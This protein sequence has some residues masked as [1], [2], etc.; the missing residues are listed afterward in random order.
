[1]DVFSFITLFGGLALFLYGMTVMS[2][3]LE[4]IAGGQLETILRNMTSNKYKALG[5]GAGVTA[6]IQS[7]SAVTV[8]LVGLVNS[9]IM[10]TNQSIGVIMGSN[11]GTTATAWILSLVGIGNDNVWVR[12]LNPEAFSPII[13]L[14]GVIMF[15][16]GRT[17]KKRD[18][19]VVLVGF[20]IL[21]Y[22]MQLM[23]SAM[24]PLK[25]SPSFTGIL[26]AF[27]NP[28]IGVM[29][30]LI[31]TAV[32]QSSSAS[33]GILQAMSLTN[34]LTY[35]MIIPI[36]MGQNIGTC[37]TVLISSIGVNR[38]A[39][40][41][42]AVHVSF[43][44]IGTIVFTTIFY[45]LNHFLNFA[46]LNDTV[47]PVN[48]AL[49]HTTFN[50]FTTIIL[51][52]FVDALDRLSGKIVKATEEEPSSEFLDKRLLNTPS[53]A[54]SEALGKTKEMLLIAFK[55]LKETIE[56][57]DDFSVDKYKKIRKR[58][59]KL[60]YYEDQL[61]SFNV[62]ITEN[63]LSDKD[64]ETVSVMLHVITSAERIGDHVLNIAESVAELDEKGLEFS[65]TAAHELH[66]LCDALNETVEHTKAAFC[67]NDIEEAKLVEP[68]E[69]V[70]D[71]LVEIIKTN[72]IRRL[73]RG[74][75]TI[76]L[77]FIL[78]DVLND[79]ERISDHCSDIAATMIEISRNHLLTHEY[80]RQIKSDP[81]DEFR[82]MYDEYSLKY[83]I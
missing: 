48:I 40:R 69:E 82:H 18:T 9:G 77:G 10:T 74:T 58:E 67:D 13:A 65:R 47:G 14:V 23:S 24:A 61:A 66:T 15:M 34:G 51:L 81:D 17:N 27:S 38:S 56:L 78:N 79:I 16:V 44:V 57:S 19:G 70:I 71:D 50:V 62:K 55:N 76:E 49:F 53:V 33:V 64:S 36:V 37:V 2:Q 6:V 30:G 46:F 5:L 21:M 83:K 29:T 12:L 52:P 32:I 73:K 20:A 4:K 22:G 11:I 26:T 1:M 54:V 42:A 35:G 60:D 75:C 41:V 43:N 39:K 8:M 28:L 7:S 68:L 63:D 80:M 45:T 3:G 72:H 59:N 25:D 31:I